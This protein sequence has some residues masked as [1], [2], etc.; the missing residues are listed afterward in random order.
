MKNHLKKENVI[1][2]TVTVRITLDKREERE[3]EIKKVN[4]KLKISTKEQFHL[5]DSQ[6][7]K[8]A[9]LWFLEAQDAQTVVAFTQ[10][11]FMR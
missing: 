5:G 2:Q 8:T 9:I 4:K 11:T 3:R 6:V 1:L 7:A 10:P